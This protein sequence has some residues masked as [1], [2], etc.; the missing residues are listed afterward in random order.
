MVDLHSLI[1][2][3]LQAV[4]TGSVTGEEERRHGQLRE[5]QWAASRSIGSTPEYFSDTCFCQLTACNV[6]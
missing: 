6:M 2:S 4:V 1:A 3:N 5:Q